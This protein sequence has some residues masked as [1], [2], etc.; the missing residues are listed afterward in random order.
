MPLPAPARHPE[1]HSR[2]LENRGRQVVLE[3]VRFD[4]EGVIQNA[5][6]MVRK[7]RK[8]GLE[9][10]LD[11]RPVPALRHL[12]GDQLRLG[13]VLINL[14]SNAVKFTEHGHV[15]LRVGA[16]QND[17]STATVSFHVE[18]TGIG[19]TAEQLGRLFAEFSQADGSTTRKYGGTGLGLAISKRLVGAMNGDL[20]VGSTFGQGSVFHFAVRMPLA[21][22]EITQIR[23]LASR[24]RDGVPWW[25]TTTRRPGKAWSTC[26][27]RWA[28]PAC[29]AWPTGPRC[30]PWRLPG[31][32]ARKTMTCWSR[33]VAARHERWR[34]DH[35][36]AGGGACPARDDRRFGGDAALLRQEN[37][38]PGVADVVQKP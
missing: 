11:Y 14:L 20:Q 28:A 15:R 6:F 33:L 9:L 7:G 31:M 16:V 29:S 2:F 10:L 22:G 26:C 17:D 3:A 34:T 35:P 30:W 18:D 27:R 21:A 38:P 24:W 32:A 23:P 37:I 4:L 36:P 1:R 12:V 25:S 13:Q 19:M 5:L 8:P